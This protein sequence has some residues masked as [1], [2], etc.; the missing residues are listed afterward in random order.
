MGAK[1]LHTE[2]DVSHDL[3]MSHIA[4]PSLGLTDNAG[5]ATEKI[6]CLH[7]RKVSDLHEHTLLGVVGMNLLSKW[8]VAQALDT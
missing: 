6:F 2:K 5:S 8:I 1:C 7:V 4:V 3:C